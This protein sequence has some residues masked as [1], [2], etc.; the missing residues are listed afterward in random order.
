MLN[1]T[2]GAPVFGLPAFLDVSYTHSAAIRHPLVKLAFKSYKHAL[3]VERYKV[4][5]SVWRCIS[6]RDMARFLWEGA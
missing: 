1:R 3:G 2:D 4:Q 6:Q 5:R